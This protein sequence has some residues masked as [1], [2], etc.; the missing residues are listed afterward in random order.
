MRS[1]SSTSNPDISNLHNEPFANVMSFYKEVVRYISSS[2]FH[3]VEIQNA[4][5]E[6]M[7]ILINTPH[8]TYSAVILTANE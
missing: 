3:L 6:I 7:C 8:N 2:D 5:T 1:R 4:N